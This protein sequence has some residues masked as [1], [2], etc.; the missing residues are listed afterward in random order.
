MLEKYLQICSNLRNSMSDELYHHG[1]KGQQWGKRNG[2]P[3]PLDEEDHSKNE[4]KENYKSSINDS[5]ENDDKENTK[6]KLTEE[7]QQRAIMMLQEIE[8]KKAKKV[9]AVLGLSLATAAGMYAAS[10]IVKNSNPEFFKNLDNDAI[11]FGFNSSGFNHSYNLNK[12][13][14]KNNS[15][16]DYIGSR[17]RH[18]GY[19]ILDD[20]QFSRLLEEK[21]ENDTNTDG[22]LN[23]LAVSIR[24]GF[25]TDAS[26]R[27]LSCWSGSNAYFLDVL[28]GG[29]DRFVS[30]SF[31][32]LV[33]FNDFGSLYNKKPTIFNINGV[34][35]EDFVGKFGQNHMRFGEGSSRKLVQSIFNNMSANNQS[36]DGKFSVGFI[37]AAYHSCTCTH[38]WNFD[39]FHDGG[40]DVMSIVD[41]YSGDRY[42]IGVKDSDGRIS[43]MMSG[44]SK[45]DK[46]LKHYN[47]DS[48]RFYMPTLDSINT[49]VMS[50]VVL[51]RSSMN[52]SDFLEG[53]N[54]NNNELYHHGIKGQRWGVRRFQN[55]DGTLT[56]EGKRRY[57]IEVQKNVLKDAKRAYKL[58]KRNTWKKD[59][60]RKIGYGMLG[61]QYQSDAESKAEINYIDQKAKLAGL[62]SRGNAEKAEQRSYAKSMYPSGMSG[63]YYDVVNGG[64]STKIHQHLAEKRGEDYAH[65][66]E[67]RVLGRYVSAVLGSAAVYAGTQF[68]NAYLSNKYNRYLNS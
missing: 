17:A 25:T 12:E 9:A 11:E 22:K 56:A 8:Y 57:D 4:I 54:M 53:F 37:N 55:E 44:L 50:N 29:D 26:S 52:H 19:D 21:S 39:I 62:K 15:N 47:A 59:G 16:D 34:E 61:R 64:R 31:T 46:E 60:I 41:T 30:K 5:G 63:S 40:R 27:R 14:F 23:D 36:K 2:P 51:G 67:S 6:T 65:S 32:N 1:I 10:Y 42:K 58:E 3:Y 45:L 28:S 13:L 68:A 20:N 66:V 33:N 24:L 35:C 48:L 49:S 7:E 38:Q 18:K 43:Y